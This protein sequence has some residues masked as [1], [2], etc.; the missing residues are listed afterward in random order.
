MDAQSLSTETLSYSRIVTRR[1]RQIYTHRLQWFRWV[2]SLAA[3]FHFS[4]NFG[5]LYWHYYSTHHTPSVLSDFLAFSLSV[6]A[7][8]TWLFLFRDPAAF[9]QFKRPGRAYRWMV[10]GTV[11]L[12]TLPNSL[13]HFWVLKVALNNDTIVLSGVVTA[14]LAIVF[15]VPLMGLARM[16][17]GLE[18]L[19]RSWRE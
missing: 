9:L 6:A 17:D 14:T 12:T 11:A 18:V 7:R 4:P 3:T 2:L 19:A 15:L 10:C 5:K 1:W 8:F 13:V 16:V